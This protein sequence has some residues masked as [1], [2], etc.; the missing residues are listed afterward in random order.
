MLK[1]DGTRL[2]ASLTAMAKIGAT[3]KGGVRRLALTEEDRR[4]RELFATWCHEAGMTVRTDEV[5]NLF[6][7]REGSDAM[8]HEV[9]AAFGKI[10]AERRLEADISTYW[11]SPATPFDSACVN[12][13]EEAAKGLGYACER[14]VSGAGHDAIHLA[15]HVPTAMVFIPCVD[16]LSHN[17][18]EDALPEDVTCGANVLI[19]AVLARAVAR[20]PAEA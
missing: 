20:T 2:W 6:A 13:V 18:S 4:G 19:N 11:K 7:R 3:P 17:E 8:E 15:R 9:R 12:L 5:G 16:G 14:I 1:I 10:A